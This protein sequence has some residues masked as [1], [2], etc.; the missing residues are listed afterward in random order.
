MQAKSLLVCSFLLPFAQS[1]IFG[2]TQQNGR[3]RLVGSSFGVLGINATFDYVVRDLASR[4]Q[5]G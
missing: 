1:A 2:F 4:R 5:P 3:T